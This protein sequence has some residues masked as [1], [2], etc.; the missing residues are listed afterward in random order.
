LTKDSQPDRP[1]PPRPSIALA[2]TG[3]VAGL[4]IYDEISS[5]PLDL[6]IL[7]GVIILVLFWNGQAVDGLLR[8]WR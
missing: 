1:A 3:V 4:A 7:C 6:P 8:K 5:P 2:L